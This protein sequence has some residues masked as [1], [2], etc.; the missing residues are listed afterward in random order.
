LRATDET[1]RGGKVH[2]KGN[3]HCVE[4]NGNAEF[5]VR[6]DPVFLGALVALEDGSFDR[7]YT[8]PHAVPCGNHSLVMDADGRSTTIS[9]PL[10]VTCA[11]SAAGSVGDPAGSVGDAAGSVGDDG[12][13]VL[14]STIA[15]SSRGNGILPRTGAD[16]F[17]LLLWALILLAF[18]TLLV[19]STWRWSQ[20]FAP[21]RALGKRF[22]PTRSG[23]LAA[24]PAPEV[25]FVDTS[26]FVPYRSAP[27]RTYPSRSGGRGRR[28]SGTTWDTA[29]K[30]ESPS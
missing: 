11:A 8:L 23:P 13:R 7:T 5:T 3:E 24:L 27:E 14:G 1:K 9:R 25:P 26:R 21:V 6:S 17:R 10:V 29:P 12:T 22:V 28:T 18:G 4:P 19:M 15:N 2:V 20:R 30:N 16:L